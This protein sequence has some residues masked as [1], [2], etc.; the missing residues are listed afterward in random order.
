M[1]N[2]ALQVVGPPYR[3]SLTPVRTSLDLVPTR[4]GLPLAAGASGSKLVRAGI[5]P[6]LVLASLHDCE[7]A[8]LGG[9]RGLPRF[10]QQP[11]QKGYERRC[12][13]SQRTAVWFIHSVPIRCGAAGMHKPSIAKGTGGSGRLLPISVAQTSF[14]A[15]LKGKRDQ[16]AR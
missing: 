4:L 5:T 14:T 13:L 16:K 2:A 1:E 3:K 11:F 7:P 9:Q 12:Q 15:A 8:D 10:V 6:A